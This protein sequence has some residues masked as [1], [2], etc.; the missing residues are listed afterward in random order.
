MK[1]YKEIFENGRLSLSFFERS[2][3]MLC[4]GGFALEQVTRRRL[5]FKFTRANGWEHLSVSMPNTCPSWEAMCYMKEQFWEDD[6]ACVEYHPKKEDYVN[7]HPYC[8][9]IWRPYETELPTPPRIMVGIKDLEDAQ[10]L[11]E[12]I[13]KYQMKDNEIIKDEYY[14]KRKFDMLGRPID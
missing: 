2:E 13:S 4:C 5:N 12:N 3:N 10:Y 6:E 1:D 8:L 14:I 9:H 11:A 7:N